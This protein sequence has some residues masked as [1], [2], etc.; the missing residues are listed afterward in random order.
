MSASHRRTALRHDR[1]E[2]RLDV[3]RRARDHPQDLARG[4][5]LLER[6]QLLASRVEQAHVLDRDDRLVGEG[7]EELICLSV[8]GRICPRRMKT[9]PDGAPSRRSGISSRVRILRS[10]EPPG[11]GHCSSDKSASE[12]MSTMW[13]GSRSKHPRRAASGPVPPPAQKLAQAGAA[14]H[15]ALTASNASPSKR[16][17]V[18]RSASQSRVALARI[19]SKTGSRSVGDPR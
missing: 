11:A 14:P 7:L 4:R 5:L 1:L 2:H 19:A 18:P 6:L 13:T 12:V 8:N 9:T 15:H 10:P 17:I 3:G 16:K